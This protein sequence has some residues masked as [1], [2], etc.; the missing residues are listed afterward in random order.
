M[1]LSV[2]PHQSTKRGESGLLGEGAPEILRCAQDDRGVV[3]LSAAKDLAWTS[4]QSPV[5]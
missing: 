2:I 1:K 3:I 5:K 4:G